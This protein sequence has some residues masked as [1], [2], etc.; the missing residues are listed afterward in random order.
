M[1]A[2]EVKDV[3]REAYLRQLRRAT[4]ETLYPVLKQ[5]HDIVFAGTDCLTCARCCKE[6]PAM[7]TRSDIKRLAAYLGIPPKT[8]VRKYVLEDIN[9]EMTLN[10]VPCVFLQHDNRCGVYDIRPNACRRYPHTDEPDYPDRS[11][12]NLANA[13]LCPAAGSILDRLQQQFPLP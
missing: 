6:I 11:S 8:F 4:K 9:G 10:G 12:L 1:E 13:R 7:V 2:E 5:V 3:A